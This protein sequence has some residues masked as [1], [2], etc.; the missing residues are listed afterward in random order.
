MSDHPY[1]AHPTPESMMACDECWNRH[2][3]RYGGSC[4]CP[5]CFSRLKDALAAQTARAEALERKN[6]AWQD[7]VNSVWAEREALAR[8]TERLLDAED[9]LNYLLAVAD[10]VA[11]GASSRTSLTVAVGQIRQ[12]VIDWAKGRAAAAGAADI[13]ALMVAANNEMVAEIDGVLSAAGVPVPEEAGAGQ[14][15][16]TVTCTPTEAGWRADCSCGWEMKAL[17]G[18]VDAMFAARRQADEHLRS[19]SGAGQEGGE[20]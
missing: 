1:T 18:A 17:G 19:V 2:I 15:G 12:G 14:E 20:S 7:V 6:G 4:N 10:D 13:H 11:R 16:H 8:E 9:A 5:W 3:M